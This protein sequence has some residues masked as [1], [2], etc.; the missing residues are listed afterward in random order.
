MN[1]LN[2][3]TLLQGAL[4]AASANLLPQRATAQEVANSPGR[5]WNVIDVNVSLFQWPFRRLPYDQANQL[6]KKLRALDIKQAWCGSFEGVLHRDVSGVNQR[7]TETCR[8][9]PGDLLIPFGTINLDLPGWEEDLRRCHEVHQMPGIRLHPNYHG[10]QLGDPRFV[11]L[12]QMTAERGLVVQL[13]AALED[14]R[15]QH[16]Q[17][18]VADVD[19]APL[20]S[21][22]SQV[23]QATVL[24]LNW[25]PK[26]GLLE[27]LR[28]IPRLYFDT[29]RTE[30]T[31]GVRQLVRSVPSGRVV[32]GTHAPFLIF[33]SALIR[34]Y[35]SELTADE[36]AAV[37]GQNAERLLGDGRD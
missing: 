37:L 4:A 36:N 14:T 1:S 20:A 24:L 22:M 34:V 9:V 13:A 31:D 6:V 26:A 11:R 15:T 7:L 35:E 10:Y 12:L 21:V 16:P 8:H 23:P 30:A 17:L 28:A 25:R 2:R 18:Q 33:E 19:L 32:F 3:R 5:P 29:A 27:Q